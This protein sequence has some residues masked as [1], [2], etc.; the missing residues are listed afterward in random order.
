MA[1]SAAG[2]REL[3]AQQRAVLGTVD[4][5]TRA[6]GEPAPAAAVARRLGITHERVRQYF[7]ALFDLGWLRGPATPAVLARELD[8]LEKIQVPTAGDGGQDPPVAR[9]SAAIHPAGGVPRTIELPVLDFRADV[10]RDTVDLEART[11]EVVWTTGAPVQRYDWWNDEYYMEELSLEP[12]HVRLERL[13]SVG[14]L[15]DAHSAYSVA[16]QIGAVVP[17][18]VRL[19]KGEGRATVRFSKREEVAG[20][21]Q[22]VVDRILRT[23]S[24]GYKAF[25]YEE[26]PP[27]PKNAMLIRK[28]IDWEP[29]ELSMVPIPADAGAV[30]R[31]AE[32]A[33]RLTRADLS[34]KVYPCA[35]IVRGT[36][37]RP[38][39]PTNGG[40]NAGQSET[41]VAYPPPPVPPPPAAAAPAARAADPT[42]SEIATRV[43]RERVAG[44]RA[45]CVAARMPRDYETR[46][47]DSGVALSDA[48]GQVLEELR[49]R[50]GDDRGPTGVGQD[51]GTVVVGDDPLV[52]VRSGI[53]GALLHRAAPTLFKLDDN[54]RQYRGMTFLRTAEAM[55][56]AHG[57]RTSGLGPM[58][59]AGAALGWQT[60]GGMHSTSDFSALLGDVANKVL[61]AAYEEKP[62]TF[63]AIGS[64][65]T[66]SDFKPSNRV[67]LGNAPALL[68][69]N[70]HGEFKRG[71]IT[72][73]KEVFQLGT[74]GRMFAITRQAIINDDTD[75]FSRVALAF[76]RSAR[77]LES[78][79]AWAEITS[80]PVMGDGVALFHTASHFN[81]DAVPAVIN[82]TTLSKARAAVRTQKDLDGVTFLNLDPRF[83]IV[84]AVLETIAQQH[85]VQITAQQ[86]SNV[87]PFPGTLTPIVEPRLDANSL[88]AWYLA[89]DPAQVDLLWY[90]YLEGQDGPMTESR[91]GWEVD[92]VEIK[93][94]HDFAVKAGDW[95]GFYKNPGA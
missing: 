86:A 32:Q 30:T 95:R 31:E 60:R 13:N 54:A 61:R 85:L 4:A 33:G 10:Q 18:T 38:M 80:N 49:R 46:L 27:G 37:E 78:D 16:S 92:G 47:I 74:Y 59:L 24:V 45:A 41:I 93:A 63:K 66:L 42:D 3:T 5:Y 20:I 44:I 36:E 19:L 73:G 7:R 68:K 94:R 8:P 1:S 35:I 15:L 77:T 25:R 75:A 50:G 39:E 71:T 17:G 57:V 72:E 6:N 62:A 53:M 34:R 58:E 23:V 40:Q 87:N 29:Y 28:A 2:P 52:H 22:D 26:T 51:R 9:R 12:A 79:L 64:R 84:P 43:E 83:I 65:V 67:Q 14:P 91:L 81:L 48:R 55:L 88:T 11:V 56:H 70:E 90:A 69:V 82:L 89:A 21:W 76:G